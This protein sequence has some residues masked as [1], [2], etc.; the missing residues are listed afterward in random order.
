MRNIKKLFRLSVKRGTAGLLNLI[1]IIEEALNIMHL[2]FE[3]ALLFVQIIH[4]NEFRFCLG[5]IQTQK[6]S[7]HYKRKLLLFFHTTVID[8][9]H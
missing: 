7:G 2:F 4:L 6:A 3:R 8:C 1:E 5:I 9:K